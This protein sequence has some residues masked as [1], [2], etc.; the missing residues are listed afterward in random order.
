MVHG[1]KYF[2]TT[3]LFKKFHVKTV[4]VLMDIDRQQNFIEKIVSNTVTIAKGGWVKML[5]TES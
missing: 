4:L 1:G 2:Y 3:I 5:S